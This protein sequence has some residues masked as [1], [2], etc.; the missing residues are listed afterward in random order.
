MDLI[1]Q[2]NI[3]MSQKMLKQN[4]KYLV[5]TQ[6]MLFNDYITDRLIQLTENPNANLAVEIN[7]L[8]H[9]PSLQQ[10]QL[11]KDWDYKELH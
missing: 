5:D 4:D 10:Q 6:F 9:D 3:V 8:I 7:I 2:L 11:V 1:L